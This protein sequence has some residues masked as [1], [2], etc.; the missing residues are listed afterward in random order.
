V[1]PLCLEGDARAT[2]RHEDL[3]EVFHVFPRRLREDDDVIELH[4]ATLP[5]ESPEDLI[6]GPLVA[7]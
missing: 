2:Q 3:P 1:A 6:D 4:E 7:G 5:L